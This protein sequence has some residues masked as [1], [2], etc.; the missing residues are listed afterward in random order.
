MHIACFVKNM[1]LSVNNSEEEV[2]YEKN[3]Y[4]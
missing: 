3:T 4:S 2:I 1:S